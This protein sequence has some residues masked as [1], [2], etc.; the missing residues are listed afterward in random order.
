MIQIHSA[1]HALSYVT[2]YLVK[3]SNLYEWDIC[4]FNLTTT[5]ISPQHTYVWYVMFKEHDSNRRLLYAGEE[6]INYINAITDHTHFYLIHYGHI[7]NLKH[8]LLETINNKI[9][10]E[11]F[12]CEKHKLGIK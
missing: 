8:K 4:T 7:N 10:F 5:I 1:K 12:N 2:G 11:W 6:F 3:K 9:S